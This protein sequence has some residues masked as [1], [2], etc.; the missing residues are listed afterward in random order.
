[1]KT[2]AQAN[3]EPAAAADAAASHDGAARAVP[4]LSA[5]QLALSELRGH[6]SD[7]MTHE[8]G[9]RRGTNAEELHQLRVAARRIEATLGLFKHQLPARLVHARVGAKG[10]LRGLGAARDFD[11]Q[12]AE[13]RRY[14]ADLPGEERNAAVALK[15][16]LE[17]G[18]AHARVRMLAM[19]DSEATRHW[20]ETLNLAS[21][22]FAAEAAPGAAPAAVVMP[23][24][25]RRRFRKLR[26]AVRQLDAKSSMRDYHTVR[27]RAKQ[28]RY[29]LECGAVLFG[30]PAEELLKALRRLQ[31]RLGA[32]QDAD[33]AKNRLAELAASGAALPPQTLFLMGR[34]AENHL[35]ATRQAR[36]TLERSWSKVSGKRW[37]TLRSRME[38]LRRGTATAAENP[39]LAPSVA[40]LQA[41]PAG[42]VEDAP[43]DPADSRPL[44]H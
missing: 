19:L 20:L 43:L 34:L 6:L 10:V 33:M 17:E 21:A 16:R 28:L 40:L 15:E 38:D 13:L 41:Q 14:C 37:K 27:R 39:D 11:V 29:A 5:Q 8:P 4:V 32:H 31:D 30:K 35:T 3:P 44:R 7:W 1:M 18:R 42:P 36:R 12:L 25:V 22:D 24:R 23:E 9:A 26:K 2:P